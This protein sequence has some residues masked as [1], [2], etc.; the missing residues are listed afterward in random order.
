MKRLSSSEIHEIGSLLFESMS[1][2]RLCPFECGVNRLEGELGTCN[3]SSQLRIASC[4]L[5]FGEEPPLSGGG[6]SGTIFL[7]NCSLSCIYCQN[8]PISQLGIGRDISTKELSEMMLKLQ[9][10]G[11]ENINFVTPSH[12]IPMLLIALSQAKKNGLIIPI[13]YNCSGYEKVEIIRHLE[14][15]I[16]IYLPDMRYNDDAN[17]RKYSGCEDYSEMNRKAIKE[18]HR[19]VGGLV[20]DNRGIAVSGIIIRHLVLPGRISGSKAILKFLA[21]NISSDVYISLM[22][23]YFPAYSAVK[24]CLLGRRINN[25]EFDEV[26]DAFQS[27]GLRN[28]FIQQLDYEE[29]H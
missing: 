13:V 19:Q 5:H 16:D 1:E 12:M 6:G 24:D 15:I 3:S 29:V 11:A 7:S 23:Q 17:A 20:M 8:Y 28:G 26:V 22:S 10:Q 18:M 27:L 14:G 2:C 4:N 21:E 9:S 25:E